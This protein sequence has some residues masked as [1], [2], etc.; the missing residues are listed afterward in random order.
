MEKDMNL[1]LCIQ[2]IENFGETI[3]MNICTGT[4][5][6]VSWGQ[7]DYFAIIGA[8]LFV[9]FIIFVTWAVGS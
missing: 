1:S 3:Y 9:G 5:T 7:M 4:E 8:L 6:A 2:T